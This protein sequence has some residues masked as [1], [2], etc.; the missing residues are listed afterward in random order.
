MKSIAKWMPC[1]LCLC[2][3]TLAVAKTLDDYMSEAQQL[4]EA[5]T[6]DKAIE[7]LNEAIKEYPDSART[8]ITLGTYLGER[9]QKLKDF[10]AMFPAIS[11]IFMLWDKALELEPHNFEARFQRGAWAVS[12]PKFMGQ[13]EKG[14]E[15]MQFI[16]STLEQSPDPA[17]QE[18]LI[19]AL[20]YM[21][22]GTQRT[23]EYTKAK[24]LFNKV[25]DRAPET[26]FAV[27]AQTAVENITVVERWLQKRAEGERPDDRLVQ[28]LKAQL[29]GKPDDYATLLSLGKAYF[30]ANKYDRALTVFKKA[31]TLKDNDAELYKLIAQTYEK[32]ASSGYDP[33]IIVDTDFL[34]DIAFESI[35]ML[36]KAIALAPDDL[37]LRLARATAG[38]EMPFFVG[39]LDQSLLDLTLITKSDAPDEIKAQ[40]KYLLGVG[41]KKKAM[42]QWIEVVS[43]YPDASAAQFVFQELYPHVD[44]LNVAEQKIPYVSID[45]ILGFK[46]ELAPQTAVWVEDLQGNYIAT[47]YVSGFS[48]HAKAK[49]VN[50]PIWSN[51]SEF[52]AVDGVTGASIDL[53]HHILVWNTKDF[54]DKRVPEGDYQ[55]HI[56]V[57]FWPSMQYQHVEAPI[58]IGKKEDH[59]LV[60]EGNLIPY[61][62]V[63]YKNK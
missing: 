24:Q 50:L 61:L 2:F 14:I 40:A 59:A 6:M 33:R 63:K 9:V 1:I 20:Y 56:E 19:Q 28:T 25:I 31:A 11:Q 55:I 41:Y 51:K 39:R 21:A 23:G 32:I 5:G 8:Y 18:L 42:S 3:S 60:E 53:G 54:R 16:T 48:G 37:E 57:A 10:S 15:D 52:M 34:T 45:F 44:R 4:K 17:A 27:R 62:E 58:R 49:Q 12:I 13:L 43:A 26:E 35:K 22:I 47:V 46:D 38:I 29:E 30:S 7:L 36:D